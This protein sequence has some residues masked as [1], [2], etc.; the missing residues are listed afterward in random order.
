M[1]VPSAR[2]WQEMQCE[3]AG[4][5]PVPINRGDEYAFLL[6]VPTHVIKAVYRSC[7]VTL[8]VATAA[9]LV[10]RVIAT[11]LS[12]AD[13]PASPLSISGVHR[14]QEE[15]LALTE[16]LCLK[17]TLFVFFDELSRPVAR[18][19]CVLDP[20]ACSEALVYLKG[21]DDWYVGP[22]IS[23]LA[24][25]LDEVDTIVDP[26]HTVQAKH[27]PTLIPVCLTLSSFETT[28]IVA[29]G[30]VESRSFRLEDPEEGQGLEQTTWHLLVDLFGQNIFHSPQVTE[31]K[32]TR[33]LTDILT[34]CEAGLCFFEAKAVAVL[35]TQPERSTER[36]AKNI[37]KQID[38]GVSQ[39]LGGM[40]SVSS[41]LP[42]TSKAGLPI[43]LLDWVGPNRHSVIMVSEL[44]PGVDWN[45]VAKQ[46][47]EASKAAGAMLHVLDLQELRLLVGTSKAPIALMAHLIRR[48]EIMAN[49]GSAFIRSRLEGPPLL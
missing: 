45:L 8:S 47:I 12:V 36:R 49:V 46:L 20:V 7:P 21:H 14:H 17:Q 26:T 43:Q 32:V 16:T 15:Q 1:F 48:F 23:A 2:I 29:L 41:S 30:N 9:T 4:F 27:S 44:Y 42:L 37:Q 6:K 5:W 34:L 10:G 13:D 25:V 31:G 38:K 11:V 24:E 18:A 19:H 35:S 28:K 22:W 40:R 3:P 39:L 33:E